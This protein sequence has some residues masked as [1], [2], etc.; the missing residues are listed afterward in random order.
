MY[1]LGLE[2]YKPFLDNYSNEERS[3]IEQKLNLDLN[4]RNLLF[5]KL[6]NNLKPENREYLYDFFFDNCSTRPRDVILGDLH[7]LE[8]DSTQYTDY[9]FRKLLDQFTRGR[10]WYDFGI[11][12]IIGCI[13]DKKAGINEQMFLPEYLMFH[14]QNASIAD[15]PLVLD[16]KLVLDY[17]HKIEKR[18]QSA[19][20]GPVF[21]FAMILMLE[22]IL[23]LTRKKIKNPFIRIYD[24]LVFTITGIASIIIM[25]MWFGT[26]HIATKCNMNLL[27]INPLFLLNVFYKSRKLNII[28]LTFCSI[29]ILQSA[30]FQTLHPAS[31][32]ICL[33]LIL[34]ILRNTTSIDKAIETA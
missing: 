34:K 13:A 1:W 25:F 19:F 9:T 10:V 6:K 26:D 21:I 15:K 14:I 33:V 4:Q 30:F 7:Q 29:A 3:V 32:M 23:F 20:P 11:D 24:N 2:R 31:L 28:L 22:L 5:L 27:W 18:N 16:K 12:L 17:E 8:L